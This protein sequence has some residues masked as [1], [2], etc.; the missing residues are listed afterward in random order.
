MPPLLYMKPRQENAR[1][2]VFSP[3]QNNRRE[4]ERTVPQESPDPPRPQPTR[5]ARRQIYSVANKLEQRSVMAEHQVGPAGH[6]EFANYVSSPR[7]KS[8]T[9]DDRAN[10]EKMQPESMGTRFIVTP[11]TS[12][13]YDAD[14]SLLM[15]M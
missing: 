4:V 8:L 3:L 9:W 1:P 6:Q 11:R 14:I 7:G 10:I 13:E 2:P 5:R 12:L 15:G